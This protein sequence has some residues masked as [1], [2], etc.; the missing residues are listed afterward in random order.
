MGTLRLG[1]KGQEV[2]EMT[3]QLVSIGLLGSPSTVFDEEVEGAVRAWQAHGI[4]P[5][6]R[7]LV[8]D[9]IYGPMTAASLRENVAD[10]NLPWPKRLDDFTRTNHVADMIVRVALE[11]LKAGAREIGGNNQGP[12]VEKYHR[13]DK[14]S[15]YEWAWCAAFTSWCVAE[16]CKRLEYPMPFNYTGGAQNIYK[17]FDAKGWTYDASDANPPQPGDIVVWWRG[18]TRTWKGHVGIVWDFKDGVVHV[19]EGNVGKYPAQVA[20][21]AYNLQDMEKLLGFCRIPPPTPR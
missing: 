19:I 8:V 12:W 14:A 10:R 18:T 13:N 21:F 11:E 20:I 16:A 5:R 4:D 15:Q 3:S 9:G 1:S 17:Q 7:K 6:G 2:L